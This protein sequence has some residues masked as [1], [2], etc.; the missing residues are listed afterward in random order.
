[1]LRSKPAVILM[2]QDWQELD[3]EAYSVSLTNSRQRKKKKK[4][5]IVSKRNNEI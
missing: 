3:K 1:M 4:T 2:N 5:K